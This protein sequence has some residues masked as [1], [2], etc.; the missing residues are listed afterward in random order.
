MS[1]LQLIQSIIQG[2]SLGVLVLII[3]LLYR[4]TIHIADNHL[5]HITS[6]LGELRDEVR[7]LAKDIR[8]HI[9][10]Q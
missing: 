7:E 9:D 6:T 1:D 5:T 8:V 2:G 10:R 4:F 3:L